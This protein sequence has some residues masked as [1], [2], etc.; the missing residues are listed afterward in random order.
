MSL[1]EKVW[2]GTWVLLGIIACLYWGNLAWFHSDKL[3]KRLIERA[4]QH[5]DWLF[6][7]DY[8]LIF[9]D[10]YGIRMVR[11]IT[12]VVALMLLFSGGLVAMQPSG[13]AK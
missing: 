6:I 4:Q 7:K 11:F 8:T 3:K 9:S 12:L 10:A 13:I 1:F 5:P 2:F